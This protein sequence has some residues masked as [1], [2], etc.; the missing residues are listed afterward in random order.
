MPEP[1]FDGVVREGR[2]IP[3]DTARHAVGM[4]ELDGKRVR[5]TY[6]RRIH[7]ASANQHAYYRGVVLPVISAHC[8]YDASDRQDL[9]RVH[10]GLKRLVFGVE[11]RHGIEVVVSHADLDV[12]EFR[13]FLDK[14]IRWAAEEGCYIPAPEEVDF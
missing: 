14:V 6:R 11:E 4:T 2:F 13:G 8:G 12:E 1:A 3:D 7:H 9:A 10:D 5:V